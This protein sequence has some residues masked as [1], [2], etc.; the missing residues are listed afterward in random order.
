MIL[1]LDVGNSQIFGGVFNQGD[2][3]FK[4]RHNTT[5]NASSDQFGLFLK[6]V[7]RENEIEPKLI[8]DIS[9]CTV[10]PHLLYTLRN[11]CIKYLGKTPFILAPGEKTGLKILYRN[12]AE[13]GADRIANAI[14]AK[15]LYPNQNLIVVDFGTATTFCAIRADKSYLGGVIIPGLKLSMESLEQ[16]T[17][18]LPSVEIVTRDEVVGRSTVESIQSGLYFGHTFAAKGIIK[19]MI[20]ESFK[21]ESAIVI[22]TGGFAHLFDK[23]KIFDHIESNLVLKGLHIA[24]QVNRSDE[25]K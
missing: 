5:S 9:I 3:V 25:V 2:L 16:K 18:K 1:C 6:Q 8:S 23:E 4:F 22:G 20:K 21:G 15:E 7:L 17:A 19:R 12:P 10:V 24:L 11:S 14:A 13:V